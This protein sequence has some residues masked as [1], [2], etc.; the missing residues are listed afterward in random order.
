MYLICRIAKISNGCLL[1]SNNTFNLQDHFTKCKQSRDG[2]GS[3]Q[4]AR[5]KNIK[6]FLQGVKRKGESANVTW[7]GKIR[8]KTEEESTEIDSDIDASDLEQ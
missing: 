6:D 4:D 5:Q 1:V 3:V 7:K 2:Q 8:K